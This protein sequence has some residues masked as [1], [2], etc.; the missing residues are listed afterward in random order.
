MKLYENK[1][2]TIIGFLNGFPIVLCIPREESR[3]WRFYCVWCE[4]EHLHGYL[5]GLRTSHCI[6][7]ESFLKQGYYVSD[8]KFYTESEKSKENDDEKY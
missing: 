6:D 8:G 3:G 2:T 5:L 4:R 7:N 1:R